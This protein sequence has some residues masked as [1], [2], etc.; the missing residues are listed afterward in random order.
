MIGWSPHTSPLP[1]ANAYEPAS[2]H[3]QLH[4]KLVQLRDFVEAHLAEAA[5]HQIIRSYDQH[6]QRRS[7]QVGECMWLSVPTAGKLNPQWEGGWV[8]HSVKWPTTY[9]ITDGRRSKTVTDCNTAFKPA[10]EF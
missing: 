6:A 4:S 7:F 2:Y 10:Q 9:S 1:Q 3:G 5:N 8:I